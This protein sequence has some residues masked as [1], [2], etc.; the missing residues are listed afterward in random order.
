[1]SAKTVEG[2]PEYNTLTIE[3]AENGW[4]VKQKGKTVKIFIH[5]D[6]VV[7]H[8]ESQLVTKTIPGQ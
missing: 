8:L 2:K 7:K 4:I 5:W 3:A 1:M 6:R